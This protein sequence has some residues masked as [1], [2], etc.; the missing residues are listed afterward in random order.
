MN[1]RILLSSLAAIVMVGLCGCGNSQAD[2][3]AALE[4][5]KKDARSLNEWGRAMEHE[6]RANPLALVNR[7]K[8]TMSKLRAM[9]NDKLPV[10]LKEAF[11]AFVEQL[12]KMQALLAEMGN[13]PEEIAKKAAAD[14]Q[15]MQRYAEK[16]KAMKPETRRVS[17]QLDAVLT[18]YKVEKLGGMGSF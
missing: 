12:G 18:S 8:E 9:Q 17:A 6:T 7:M 10:D 15:F 4:A 5:F 1:T 2:E 13:D 3:A 16:F 11:A 14:P